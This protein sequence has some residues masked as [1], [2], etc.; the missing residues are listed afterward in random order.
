MRFAALVFMGIVL[1]ASPLGASANT[2]ALLL[3]GTG[4]SYSE[5]AEAI[6]NELRRVPDSRVVSGVVGTA[7][8]EALARESRK[9][10]IAV[11]TLATQEA[12]RNADP[13]VALLCVLVPRASFEAML[14]ASRGERRT[15]DPRRVSALFLDQPPGRQMELI[16]QALP[17]LSR[18]GMIL[19][20]N[21]AGE[22]D[23]FAVAAE[24][25]GL[26]LSVEQITRD[27]ALFPALQRVLA[28]TDVLLALP[29]PQLINAETARNLLLTSFRTRTPVIG[30]SAAYVR[31]G[32]LAA[33]YST[34]AQI[35]AQTG[36]IARSFLAAG[37]LPAPQFPKQFSVT[38]NARVARSL[39]VVLDDEAAIRERI[40]R[41]E[42][43]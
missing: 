8:A 16:R 42:R 24:G 36:E 13:N 23:R 10:L 15:P 41:R 19:G 11:G 20:P 9:L 27:T 26:K 30:Y 39:G 21:S 7:S 5:V 35:G 4:T 22:L 29:D 31:A 6:Q 28:D 43:E 37:S 17:G 2:V 14:A 33:V 25:R 40:A 18:I 3:S 38:V 32:A 12:L 34:P 1:L